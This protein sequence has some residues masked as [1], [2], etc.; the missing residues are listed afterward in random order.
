MTP[1]FSQRVKYRQTVCQGGKPKGD[2][3]HAQPVR[4][5][6]KTASTMSCRGCFPGRPPVFGAGGNSPV[7]AHRASV[8][9]E[10]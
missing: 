5:T 6:D 10:G 8:R 9:S 2:R 3:R 1:S 7:N 4:T